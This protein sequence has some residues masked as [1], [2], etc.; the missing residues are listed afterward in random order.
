MRKKYREDESWSGFITGICMLGFLYLVGEYYTNRAGY[1]LDIIYFCITIFIFFAVFIGWIYLRRYFKNKKLNNLSEQIN[2]AGLNELIENFISR[3]GLENGRY[4]NVWRYRSYAF[5]WYRL[6]DFRKDLNE[7]GVKVSMYGWKDTLLLL[8]DRI[9]KREEALTRGSIN[10]ISQKFLNLSG[11]DFEK[12]LYRL[13][14]AMGYAVQQTG[15]VGDQ[16]GDLI[17]NRELER[18]LVQAKR[19]GDYSVGNK[20]V[21][22]A[23]TAKDY[24]NCT[25]SMVVTTTSFTPEAVTLA[26]ANNVELIPKQQL[27]ELLLRYLKESWN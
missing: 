16:G 1:W 24:Y 21:Q 18:I 5:E 7:K 19:Y 17:L 26:R 10:V 13:F 23:A 8:K 15:K 9:Q 3:W 27:Q 4:K 25:K 2:K 12:L 11:T 22:E 20:A 6:N 14:E